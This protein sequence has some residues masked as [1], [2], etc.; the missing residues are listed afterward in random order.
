MKQEADIMIVAP[1]PD[2]AEFGAGGTAARWAAEG[3][4]LVLILCTNGDKGTED[5]SL[6]PGELAAIREREQ[7]E[8]AEV[9]GIQQVVFLGYPDQGLEDTD[10]FRESIV[11]VIRLYRPELVVTCDPYRRYV[12]HRDHRM[13]GQVVLDAVFPYARDHLSYPDLLAEGLEPHKVSELLFWASEETNYRSD[14]TETFPVKMRSLYC[15]RSQ[16]KGD[17]SQIE[18]WQKNRCRQMAE[19][20]AYEMAE[21]FHRVVLPR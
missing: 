21:G 2:D 20:E 16:L 14:I 7:R 8:A 15:H 12:W 17:L 1:H 9:L 6:K 10:G 4:S 5:R 18:K 19:G 11:R 3:K 13:T